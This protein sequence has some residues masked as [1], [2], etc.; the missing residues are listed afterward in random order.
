VW[1]KEK[2]DLRATVRRV[3]E[4]AREDK[5]RRPF[6]AIRRELG[7]PVSGDRPLDR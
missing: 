2:R 4:L 3:I 7:L 1:L 5:N 6:D